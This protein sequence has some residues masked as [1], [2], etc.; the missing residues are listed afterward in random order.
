MD[1]KQLLDRLDRVR[2]KYKI[3]KVK[4]WSNSKCKDE[5]NFIP[6]GFA[7]YTDR[8][9][10]INPKIS[11][12]EKILTTL[13]EVAHILLKH[14]PVVMYTEKWYWQEVE[15]ETLARDIYRS[16]GKKYTK[17]HQRQLSY[18]R[19]RFKMK[20]TKTLKV[21]TALIERLCRQVV[22]DINGS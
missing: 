16:L 15:A 8:I 10:S 9:I 3:K 12:C 2:R 19:R 5:W 20:K 18:W 14:N 7:V 22:G 21:R 11:S 6:L 17:E 13:H 1:D 4:F